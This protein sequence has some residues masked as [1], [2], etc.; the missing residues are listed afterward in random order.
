MQNDIVDTGER[1]DCK[2]P[3]CGNSIYFG[4]KDREYYIQREWVDAAGEP[5]KP[6]YCKPCREKRKQERAQ[7][8][9]QR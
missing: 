1:Y 8:E 7:R 3:N 6:K 9:A 4:S 2:T 5:I